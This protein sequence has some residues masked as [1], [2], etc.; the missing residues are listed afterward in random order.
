MYQEEKTWFSQSLMFHKDVLYNTNSSLDISIYSSTSDFR[1]YSPVAF[2]LT[3]IDGST[4]Q[5]RYVSMTYPSSSELI[6]CLKAATED[7]SKKLSSDKVVVQ[8]KFYDKTL[9]FEF[10]R[11]SNQII[12]TIQIIQNGDI[13]MVIIPYS[14][15]NSVAVLIRSY[16]SDFIKLNLDFVNRA[17]LIDILEQSKAS[18]DLLKT[19]PASIE[20]H[21]SVPVPKEEIPEELVLGVERTEEEIEGFNKF[22]DDNIDSTDLGLDKF[23]DDFNKS[24]NTTI[25]KTSHETNSD[26]VFNV[27]DGDLSKLESLIN[28][29]I[30]NEHSAQ[31]FFNSLLQKM[32]VEDDFEFLPGIKEND[33]RSLVYISKC[34]YMN[35]FHQYITSNI[36]IPSSIP[37]L[38]YK[39][40]GK[41]NESNTNLAYDLLLISVYLKCLRTKLSSRE[42]DSSRNKSIF[43]LGFRVLTDMLTFGIIER[44]DFNVV[45][46][47]LN[48]RFKHY[49][50]SNFFSKY[51][52]LLDSYNLPRI[53]ENEFSKVLSDIGSKIIGKTS[54]IDEL[55]K[56]IY[57]EKIVRLK[58]DNK[59]DL[60][61]IIKEC[62]PLQISIYNKVSNLENEDEVNSVL[63]SFKD[64]ISKEILSEFVSTKVEAP[65]R[66]KSN[67]LVRAASFYSS[68]IP[69]RFKEKFIGNLSKLTG[70]FDFN[71]PLFPIEEIG[72]GML[73]VLY[74]WNEGGIND[75]YSDFMLKV[76]ECP[77]DK[78]LI[79]AKYKAKTEI[80]S[81]DWGDVSWD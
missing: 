50:T 47:C 48:E 45:K 22:L 72:E 69:E 46:S 43:Y 14:V 2:K 67:S 34:I 64:N 5:S 74:I 75:S 20:R 9:N 35:L 81:E 52:E 49:L 39:V 80:S 23:N 76:E 12:C 41:V 38:K 28:S 51:E 21:V 61:Q 17:V 66:E 10:S 56:K 78:V 24:S 62:I 55:H 71:T 11:L 59:L 68:D 29:A 6:S 26:F 31:S 63:A 79:L 33:Y 16:I 57:G 36:P 3:I 7:I 4:K 37:L 30:I 65:K 54:Y 13:G 70:P 58:Y 32:K 73:K 15:F 27:L 8:K 77:M 18:K 60:E 19:L 53:D 42:S 40:D 44:I 25:S 1:S